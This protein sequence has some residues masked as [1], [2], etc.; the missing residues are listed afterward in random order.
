MNDLFLLAINLTRRCNLACEHCY[1]DAETLKYG[2]ENE[3]KTAEVCKLLDDVAARSNETMVVLT[4]GEPLVRRD[5]EEM[6][7]HGNALG[8]SMVVGTN[9]ALLTDRRVQS[10]KAAG[11]MGMGISLDSLD[12]ER[13]DKF[14]GQPGSWAKTLAGM[15]ACRRHELPFQV[16]FSVTETNADEVPAMIDFT[17]SVGARVL[18]IFFLICT[19]RGESMSDI[20]PYRYEQVLQQLVAAQAN[21]PDLIIRARCAPHYKRVAFQQDPTSPLTR[22]EGYEGGGCL[23]GI[24]YCRITPEGA[25][26]ACPYIPDEEGSLRE[27]GFWDI[28]DESATFKQLRDPTLEGKCGECEFQKLCGGCRAR[29]LAMGGTL[30]DTD[31]WCAYEPQGGAIIEP[32]QVEENENISW[33]PDAE[34]RLSRIPPFLR[35]MVKKR[36]D[37]HAQEQGEQEVTVEHLATLSARRFSGGGM[38]KPPFPIGESGSALGSEEQPTEPESQF[39]WTQE[40]ITHLEAMPAFLQDGVRQVAEDVARD[41]GRLEVNMKLLQRLEEED[42]PGRKLDWETEADTLLAS[43]L[44]LKSPQIRLFVQ[45][46]VEAAAERE[47]KLRHKA[48][49]EETGHVPATVTVMPEDVEKVLTTHTAGVEWAAEAL[50]RV[51]SA[52]EFVRGGIKKAA[53]FNARREG[54]SEISSNDLTRFRNRAMM[55]AVKRMKAFG[56]TELSF[57]GFDVAREQIPRLQDNPQAVKRFASIKGYVE[58]HQLPEG[59]LGK[60]SQDLLDQMKADLA[61]NA[62]AQHEPVNEEPNETNVIPFDREGKQP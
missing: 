20:T 34:V 13:H 16:H 41:E 49:R 42:E 40:A 53:E 24:H 56:M 12:P 6:L 36:A 32:L 58:G 45:P 1:L 7:S 14:R 50:A 11:A 22:A 44:D 21:Y 52:P 30:M 55:K 9:G 38:P 8:L 18:N 51:E 62:R 27:Q 3:L 37:T 31:P 15:D 61:S 57:E 35:K 46:T 10:L 48:V 47:A 23:A 2:G 60:I 43:L 54:I 39:A 4:G 59:G 17:R 33:H 19:G 29:P 28:W 25:V 5:L 26:T